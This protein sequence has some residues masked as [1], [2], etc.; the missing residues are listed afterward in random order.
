MAWAY[1]GRGLVRLAQG[2]A[3]EADADFAKAV[4]LDPPLKGEL[5]ARIREIRGAN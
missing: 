1:A 4:K 2:R 5:D 3:S